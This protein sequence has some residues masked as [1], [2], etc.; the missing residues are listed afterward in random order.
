MSSNLAASITSTY[1]RAMD[2]V[3]QTVQVRRYSGLGASRTYVDTDARARVFLNTGQVLVGNVMQAQHK[4]T[5]LA[6]DLV[7]GGLALPLI[8]SDRIV[9]QGKEFAMVAPPDDCTRRAGDTLIAY[10]LLVRG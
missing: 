4:V 9:V 8:A 6:A 2:R 7:T 3:G 10:E 5:L 1:R